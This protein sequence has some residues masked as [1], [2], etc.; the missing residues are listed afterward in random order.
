[1]RSGKGPLTLT[2]KILT[3]PARDPRFMQFVVSRPSYN[4]VKG[5]E[6]SVGG[7][8]AKTLGFVQ[9]KTADYSGFPFSTIRKCEPVIQEA[10]KTTVLSKWVDLSMM[11]RK[12][13]GSRSCLS[14][15]R[16]SS[17][18]QPVLFVR[19][20]ALLTVIGHRDLLQLLSNL[21]GLI[22]FRL[23]DDDGARRRGDRWRN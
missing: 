15:S 12:N 23:K 21:H 5:L 6:H 7:R 10:T 16:P 2:V 3:A 13:V 1:M 20:V 17:R 4:R 14:S 22:R 8:G 18:A 9:Q 11:R 19:I